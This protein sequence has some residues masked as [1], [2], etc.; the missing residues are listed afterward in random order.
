MRYLPNSAFQSV[1]PHQIP[2]HRRITQDEAPSMMP[3]PAH[4][5]SQV[6]GVPGGGAH[7]GGGPGAPFAQ[8]QSKPGS[9]TSGSFT[10]GA[11][12]TVGATTVTAA[13]GGGSR[14][15]ARLR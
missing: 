7:G 15:K 2:P 14:K 13:G 4:N 8:S 10:S 3:V 11:G 12:T 6:G 5:T 9:A 1:P